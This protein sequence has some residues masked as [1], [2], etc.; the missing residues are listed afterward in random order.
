MRVLIN[1]PAT[2][3]Q[4]WYQAD[5]ISD[6]GTVTV[7]VVDDQGVTVATGSAAGTGAN[8]RTFNVP[9]VTKLTKL[10]ATWTSA[11]LG[12]LTSTIDVVGAF[13]F[14]LSDL[15]AAVGSTPTNTQLTDMRTRVEEAFEDECGVAFVPRYS[16]K[17]VTGYVGHTATSIDGDWRS[18]NMVRLK[19]FM[20]AIQ[21]VTVDGQA[22]TT[23]DVQAAT[24]DDYGFASIPST[25][26][27]WSQTLVGFEHGMDSP[28]A[29]V[30]YAALDYAR[31]LLTQDASIDSR[32]E[33]LITD[34][35]T[36]VFGGSGLGVPSVDR[37]IDQ[38][39][40]PSVA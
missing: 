11:T 20:R 9:A 35:G 14:S 5:T 19:P 37:V 17:K 18:R 1:T 22:L 24:F 29:P 30:K 7:T 26:A 38:Y 39:R 13:M 28:P 23:P 27:W 12:T 4:S 6:P 32:A 3:S 10:T 16:R 36:I 33:R 21:W 2:L 25:G 31:F 8:P 15:R 34:D 40:I